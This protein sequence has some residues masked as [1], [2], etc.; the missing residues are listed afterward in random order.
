[1]PTNKETGYNPD[2][3]LFRIGDRIWQN[4][5]LM[6][7]ETKFAPYVDVDEMLIPQNN[8][9][10]L[11]FLEEEEKK[12]KDAGGFGFKHAAMSFEAEKMPHLKSSKEEFDWRKLDF[13]WL[14]TATFKQQFSMGKAVSMPDRVDLISIHFI[15]RTQWPYK[16]IGV[17]WLCDLHLSRDGGRGIVHV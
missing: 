17:S 4:D 1:M 15:A 13:E 7:A 10:L 2:Y 11:E 9:S 14:K 16:E 5:C 3:H 8:Q 6:R 12:R